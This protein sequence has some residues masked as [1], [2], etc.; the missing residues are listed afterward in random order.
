MLAICIE[1]ALD[2]NCISD[3]VCIGHAPGFSE[4]GS[5]VHQ[6]LDALHSRFCGCIHVSGNVRVSM[7]GVP[8]VAL[9]EDDFEFL[10]HLKEVSGSITLTH[11]PTVNGSIILPNLRLIRGN[12]LEGDTYSLVLRNID[13]EEVIL[14]KLTEISRGSVL[15]DN[16][17]FPLCNLKRVNWLDILDNGM[18]QYDSCPNPN[19]EGESHNI[20]SQS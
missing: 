19:L 3:A 11:I 13:V 8:P 10:Y 15:V 4:S 2:C 1:S 6:I 12:E 7:L 20:H 16:S 9:S 17:Q 14:P 5:T 18:I